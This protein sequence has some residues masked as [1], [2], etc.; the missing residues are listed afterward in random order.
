[1]AIPSL[2]ELL[3]I[4]VVLFFLVFAIIFLIKINKVVE[5]E[6]NKISFIKHLFNWK[7]YAFLLLAGPVMA[8]SSMND[9][10]KY[11][12]ILF[13]MSIIITVKYKASFWKK[14]LMFFAS[15]TIFG[16]IVT[17]MIF[18][19][20][21]FGLYN[22]TNRDKNI[23]IN[24][25]IKK[26]NENL[27]IILDSEFKMLKMNH[28]H[29]DT[30]STYI[31]YVNYSKNEILSGYDNNVS[32]FENEMLEN[33]LK[34]SCNEKHTKQILIKGIVMELVYVDKTNQEIV[35]IFLTDNLC[36]PYYGK[37]K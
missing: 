37:N 32:N 14:V 30:I 23:I 18:G 3:V 6:N 35:N 13:W 8:L 25:I 29:K 11:G 2:P 12:G 9:A 24:K 17:L 5:S 28:R 19:V 34:S 20:E 36:Q 15:N 21:F 10:S 27:P 31:Q 7:Y 4:I 1:M 22:Y 16:I 33:E 26:A